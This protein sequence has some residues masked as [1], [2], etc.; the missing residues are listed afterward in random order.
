MASEEQVHASCS[1]ALALFYG[2]PL[3]GPRTDRSG[4]RSRSVAQSRAGEAGYNPCSSHSHFPEST[5]SH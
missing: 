4:S 3:L 5:G 1:A 2:F